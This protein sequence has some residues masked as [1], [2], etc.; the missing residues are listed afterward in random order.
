MSETTIIKRSGQ[1]PLRV[2][3]ELLAK[4]ESSFERSRSDYSGSPGHCEEVRIY[5]T[6]A[7]KHVLA[8]AHYTQWQGEH[9]SDEAAVF[10][11][12]SECISYLRDRVPRWMVDEL[13]GLIG[14]ENVAEDVE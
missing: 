3:G 14:A 12:L 7:G 6:A 9:D 10:P 2:R 1:A 11:A 5:R 13:V 4:A 8:I